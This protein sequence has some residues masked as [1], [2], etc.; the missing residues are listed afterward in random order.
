[1]SDQSIFPEWRSF[2]GNSSDSE[3]KGG[4]V[5]FGF[6][7]VTVD[8]P[9]FTK[10]AISY[11]FWTKSGEKHPKTAENVRKVEKTPQK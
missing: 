5:R 3:T 10:K 2:L 11:R 8:V 7:L 1:M 9:S 4:F 6:S